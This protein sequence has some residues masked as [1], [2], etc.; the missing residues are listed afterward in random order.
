MK[1]LGLGWQ[2]AGEKVV[3]VQVTST[4]TT[5]QSPATTSAEE[6]ARLKATS[7]GLGPQAFYS[8]SNCVLPAHLPSC[9]RFY[10]VIPMPGH[11]KKYFPASADTVVLSVV[12]TS[13]THRANPACPVVLI[14]PIPKIEGKVR[15]TVLQQFEQRH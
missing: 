1:L 8:N 5:H 14:F 13:A 10:P 3:T 4:V 2:A 7:I 6:S 12:S 11:N 15:K 9:R